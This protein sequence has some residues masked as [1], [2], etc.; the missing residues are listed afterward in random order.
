MTTPTSSAKPLKAGLGIVSLVTSPRIEL[1]VVQDL[2]KLFIIGSLVSAVALGIF[3]LSFVPYEGSSG[4]YL[5]PDTARHI[6]LAIFLCSFAISSALK[7]SLNKRKEALFEKGQLLEANNPI[8]EATLKSGSAKAKFS[9][10]FVI[11]SET[12]DPPPYGWKF[13]VKVTYRHRPPIDYYYEAALLY[14]PEA[15]FIVGTRMIDNDKIPEGLAFLKKAAAGG[16]AAAKNS[17]GIY[18]E[19]GRHGVKQSVKKARDLYKEAIALDYSLA[20]Y[21]LAMLHLSKKLDETV[22]PEAI[23]RLF[24]KAHALECPYA[25]FKLAISYQKGDPD[26]GITINLGKAREF[27]IQASQKH[28]E[29]NVRRFCLDEIEKIPDA[30]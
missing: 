8:K 20:M 30:V 22:T 15:L 10:Q 19:V 11:L 27:F 21:N 24:E 9:R 26:L 18:Y 5:L 14:H 12:W 16:S 23:F 7:Y 13:P 4:A 6:S 25:T 29:S 1:G 28:P 2:K 17:L 3:L